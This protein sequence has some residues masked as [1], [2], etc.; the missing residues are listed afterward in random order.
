[1][2]FDID[3]LIDELPKGFKDIAIQKWHH[4]KLITLFYMA[5]LIDGEI[6]KGA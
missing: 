4:N 1:M 6:M 2:W 5:D 3:R